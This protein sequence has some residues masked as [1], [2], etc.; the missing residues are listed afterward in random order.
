MLVI[1]VDDL[2]VAVATVTVEEMSQVQ[3][4]LERRFK[5][6][7][8]GVPTYFLGMSVV[9]DQGGRKLHLSQ[10]IYVDALMEKYGGFVSVRQSLPI[11]VGTNTVD[12]RARGVGADDKAV[13]FVGGCF[14]V[15]VREIYAYGWRRVYYRGEILIETRF[16]QG[17][18]V[19][20][21][22]VTVFHGE[23]EVVCLLAG[24]QA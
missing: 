5:T 9:Y 2:S 18:F 10:K 14:V 19:W 13:F 21:P 17:L 7:S 11:V 6:R 1:C 8:F 4:M 15:F 16:E 12:Q 20:R 3:G 22:T 23:V 24:G